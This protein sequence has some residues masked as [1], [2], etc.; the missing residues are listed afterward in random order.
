MLQ[1][2]HILVDF[3]MYSLFQNII[4]CQW[5]DGSK[6]QR[7]NFFSPKWKLMCQGKSAQHD[8]AI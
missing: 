3:E 4:N 1:A 7:S 5:Y 6:V 2:R 8:T